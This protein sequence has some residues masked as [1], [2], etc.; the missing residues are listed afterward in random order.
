MGD[1]YK[2]PSPFQL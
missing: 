1:F 2:N